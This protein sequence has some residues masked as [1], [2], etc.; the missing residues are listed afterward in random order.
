MSNIVRT[1][2]DEVNQVGE[3]ELTDAQLAAVFGAS[4]DDSHCDVDDDDHFEKFH[5]EFK[6]K[7][8][9]HLEFDFEQE[10]EKEKTFKKGGDWD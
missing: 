7:T 2:E 6:K 10:I 8:K 5:K 9:I 3:I 4:G 1:W